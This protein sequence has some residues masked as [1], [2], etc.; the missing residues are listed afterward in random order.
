MA[1]AN[2][3]V[4]QHK[5]NRSGIKRLMAARKRGKAKGRKMLAK[6]RIGSYYQF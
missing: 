5:T 4:S 2:Y 6:K 1:K 3:V